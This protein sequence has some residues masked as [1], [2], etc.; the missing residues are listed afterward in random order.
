MNEAWYTDVSDELARCLTDAAACADACEQLLE[1]AA[2]STDADLRQ[3]LFEAVILPA[4][5]S[6]VLIDL[7]DRQPLVLAA[8]TVCRDTAHVAVRQLEALGGSSRTAEAVTTL[9][10]C[11][12]SCD[13]LLAL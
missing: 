2:A 11:A 4:A 13:R 7:V 12:A 6:R 3:R 10:R 1:A 8:A 5:V 9:R